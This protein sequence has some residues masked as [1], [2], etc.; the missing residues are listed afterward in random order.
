MKN[1]SIFIIIPLL[2]FSTIGCET[3]ENPISEIPEVETTTGVLH[4]K[5]STSV[6]ETIQVRLLKDGEIV[7]QMEGDGGFTLRKIEAGEYTLRISAQGFQDTELKVTVIAG[8]TVTL[9]TITLEELSGPVS[10][11]IGLIR[12][13]RT[14]IRLPAI[15]VQLTDQDGKQDETLSSDEGI[16]NFNNLPTR[17]KFT[18]TIEDAD[19]EIH[20]ISIDPISADETE[21]LNVKLTPVGIG[22]REIE[23]EEPGEGLPIFTK[24]PDFE[25]PDG[26]RKMHSLYDALD[27][28]KNVIIVF[29]IGGD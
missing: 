14:G 3:T 1:M 6:D 21:K 25:L 20:E 4:G 28:G 2:L 12:N 15:L 22:D 27:E 11:I 10:H 23:P 18:L 24:A 13:N 9:D 26:D 7:A 19:Y 29:Y 16:F 17:Q 5:V 8:E